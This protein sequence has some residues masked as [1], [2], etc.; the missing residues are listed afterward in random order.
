MKEKFVGNSE[1]QLLFGEDPMTGLI[2]DK[3]LNQKNIKPLS[4]SLDASTFFDE[5]TE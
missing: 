4:D 3:R 1:E 5:L 2:E